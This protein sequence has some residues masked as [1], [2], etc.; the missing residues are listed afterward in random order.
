M[1]TILLRN[2]VLN[3]RHRTARTLLNG[4]ND[5]KRNFFC[6]LQRQAQLPQLSPYDVN[7]I[8]R[9]N[10]FM[11]AIPEDQ[12]STIHSYESNQVASNK[13]CEDCRTEGSFLHKKGF[14]CGIFDGHG[15]PACSQVISKRLLRYIAASL[16]DRKI[17]KEQIAKGCNS[18]SFLKCHNDN[19][20][21]V[22]EIKDIYEHS[23]SKYIESLSSQEL[24][25]IA[26]TM[27][28]AFLSLDND[29]SQE[30]LNNTNMRTMAVAMSGAVACVAHIEGLDIHLASTGDCTAVLGSVC[31]ETGKWSSKKLNQ[32][33]NYDNHQEVQ[34]I[35]MEHPKEEHDTA[36]R[37]ERLL[38]QLAP[39][40]ALGD[41]RYKWSND[42]ME[43]HVVPVFGEHA[44]PPHYYTPPYLSAKP[45]VEHHRLTV[46]DKFLVIGSDGLW[47]FLSPTQVV[48]LVGEHLNSKKSLEPI[49][50]PDE[51][52]TLQAI[53]DILAERKAGRTRKPSDQNSATHLI[54]HALGGTEY[55]IEH[56]KI[57]YYLSLP[58]D[59]VRL[60]RDDITITV[61]YF[62]TD[63]INALTKQTT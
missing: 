57:A 41:F 28:H 20:D 32:E 29:L 3:V 34:R 30:A 22:K 21:F 25:D 1:L 50:L 24:Q 46:N 56:S 7:M 11:Y 58:Q 13:P 49:K 14:I 60:Y 37:N 61:I 54:R 35:L 45:D 18:Q 36:I 31:P 6:S 48:Q 44:I 63:R 12:N 27:E 8:L 16:V 38:S 39:L 42:I 40:R 2:T 53:S 51:D 9:E 43:K 5:V 4:Q 15:G 55:G 23:F 10:E 26:T 59:V 62:N 47:D 19:V 52:V 17:L 33:H